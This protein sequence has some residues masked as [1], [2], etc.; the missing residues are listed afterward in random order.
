MSFYLCISTEE[1]PLRVKC[2]SCWLLRA[3]HPSHTMPSQCD[4]TD[5]ES[6]ALPQILPWGHAIRKFKRPPSTGSFF[7][8]CG[9]HTGYSDWYLLKATTTSRQ[10]TKLPLNAIGQ[11][12]KINSCNKSMSLLRARHYSRGWDTSVSKR[13]I[14][15]LIGFTH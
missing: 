8:C 5:G 10:E 11:Y 13:N 12:Q 3:C 9:E 1:I 15:Y 2:H 4:S 6:L 7:H 14:Y